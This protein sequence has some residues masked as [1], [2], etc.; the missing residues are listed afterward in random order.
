M[1]GYGYNSSFRQTERDYVCLYHFKVELKHNLLFFSYDCSCSEI[2]CQKL[3]LKKS[4][5]C[6]KR[7]WMD[8]VTNIDGTCVLMQREPNSWGL[9]VKI[10]LPFR[11]LQDL[12][13]LVCLF[14]SD[15]TITPNKFTA[16]GVTALI[17]VF[18]GSY[19]LLLPRELR[20]SLKL[21]AVPLWPNGT[22]YRHD[23]LPE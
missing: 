9:I 16:S 10:P 14:C 7:I 5:Q 19:L 12:R 15:D 11:A 1:V 23:T 22:F 4:R 6:D 3:S 18:W 20:A 21:L 17:C 8:H 2:L 13:V